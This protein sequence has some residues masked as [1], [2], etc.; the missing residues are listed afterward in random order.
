MARPERKTNRQE[1]AIIVD[2][3]T[4][5]SEEDKYLAQVAAGLVLTASMPHTRLETCDHPARPDPVDG[6][7]GPMAEI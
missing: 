1:T 2:N 5:S 7:I 6:V 4:V 3:P